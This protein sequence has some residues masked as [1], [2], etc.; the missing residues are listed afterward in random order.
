MFPAHIY[1]TYSPE[2]YSGGE[3]G[4]NRGGRGM[5][6]ADLLLDEEDVESEL[7]R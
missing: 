4:M 2:S 5:F 6:V 3:A 7:I 1:G